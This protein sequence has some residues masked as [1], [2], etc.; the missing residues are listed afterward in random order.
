[1]GSGASGSRLASSGMTTLQA[2][3]AELLHRADTSENVDAITFAD[4]VDRLVFDVVEAIADQVEADLG[5]L[6]DADVLAAVVGGIAE[7]RLRRS[8]AA[9]AA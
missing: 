5:D 3:A 6:G 4:E 7:D 8:L 1:M 2:L 9:M